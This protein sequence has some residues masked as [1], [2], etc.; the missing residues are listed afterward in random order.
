[1]ETERWHAV[2]GYEG[3]YE[4]STSGQVRSLDRVT[5]SGRRSSGRTLRQRV[6]ARG[7]RHVNLWLDGSATTLRVHRVVLSA[8]VGPA[9]EG[10]E[11]CHSDG[12]PSNNSVEN[13]RWDSHL[14]N[15]HD[16]IAHGHHVR[17]NATVCGRGHALTN[18]KRQRECK[19][20]RNERLSARRAGRPFDADRA[21]ALAAKAVA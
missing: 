20:C 21:D 11:G 1:M 17:A 4:V 2:P 12:D 15:I 10:T 13:L 6:D 19:P 8:F 3:H 9:P 18:V 7:Y 14:A 5:S 16:V